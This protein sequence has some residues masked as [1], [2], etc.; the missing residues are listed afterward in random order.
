VNE[1]ASYE[2]WARALAKPGGS[3]TMTTCATDPVSGDVICSTENVVLV[4]ETSKSTFKNVTN[5]LSSLLAD[6]NGDGILERVSL[7]AGGLEDFF[8]QYDN[9]GLRLAQ[10]RFYLLD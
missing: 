5:Q 3:A 7:F 8:W 1:T 4:R 6:I 9:K 10:L 2:I